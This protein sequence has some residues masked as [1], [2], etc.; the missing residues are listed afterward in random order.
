MQDIKID[1]KI[2][3]T[4]IIEENSNGVSVGKLSAVDED[5][6]E[7]HTFLLSGDS[8]NLFEVKDNFLWVR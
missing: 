4:I 3:D 1:G 5:A 7:L 6:G 2:T 8:A